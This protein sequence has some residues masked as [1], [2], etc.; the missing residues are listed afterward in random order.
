MKSESDWY[1]VRESKNYTQRQKINH[2]F[3]NMRF[4][5]SGQIGYL[6]GFKITHYISSRRC[7]VTQDTFVIFFAI[8]HVQMSLQIS[9]LIKSIVMLV[10]FLLILSTAFSNVSS[11]H[12]TGKIHNHI[13][14]IC[15]TFLY[16]AVSN[17]S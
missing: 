10:T 15:F 16:N 8:V 5:M 6:A 7:I 12:E 3:T 17:V 14:C 11:S 2:L 1:K 4:Q 13:G 9:C